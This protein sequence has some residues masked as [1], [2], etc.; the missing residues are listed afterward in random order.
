MKQSFAW[1]IHQRR[2]DGDARWTSS[3]L[4]SGSISLCVFVCGESGFKPDPW[5]SVIWAKE[6]LTEIASPGPDGVA[7]A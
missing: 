5:C 2:R 4:H 3:A 7:A 6:S 1:L